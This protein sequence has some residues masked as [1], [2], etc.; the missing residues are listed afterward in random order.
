MKVS[1]IP[2]KFKLLSILYNYYIYSENFT[3]QNFLF[4]YFYNKSY[5]RPTKLTN[6]RSS[7]VIINFNIFR[8]VIRKF[9]FSLVMD[10][11]I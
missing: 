11:F 9:A 1:P 3:L 2:I 6:S 10:L 4:T 5:Y 7:K 8:D